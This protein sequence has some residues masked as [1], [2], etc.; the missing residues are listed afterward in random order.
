MYW[1]ASYGKKI[2]TIFYLST[3]INKFNKCGKIWLRNS[4]RKGGKARAAF[5]FQQMGKGGGAMSYEL[6]MLILAA[7]TFIVNCLA[8]VIAIYIYFHE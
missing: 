4:L 5:P 3:S 2:C 6:I 8:V 7:M 1:A